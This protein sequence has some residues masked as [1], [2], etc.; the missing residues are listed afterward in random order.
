MYQVRTAEVNDA[1]VND[2]EAFS[3][4]LESLGYPSDPSFL[5]TRI[6]AILKNPDAVLLVAASD[7]SNKVVGLLSM[8]SY[9]NSALKGMLRG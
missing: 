9:L 1:E 7:S 5:R 4:L 6:P 2:A 3:P 8:H